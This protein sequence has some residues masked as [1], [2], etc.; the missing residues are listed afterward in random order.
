MQ[1]NALDRPEEPRYYLGRRARIRERVRC[2]FCRAVSKVLDVSCPKFSSPRGTA[3]DQ[4][5]NA[6]AE[7]K[8][9]FGIGWPRVRVF[10]GDLFEESRCLEIQFCLPVTP[11]ID[12]WRL[13]NH[14][15]RFSSGVVGFTF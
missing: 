1:L 6:A 8:L 3:P 12:G 11:G 2:P 10:A 14:F 13:R 15:P 9:L 4:A 5:R 7:E